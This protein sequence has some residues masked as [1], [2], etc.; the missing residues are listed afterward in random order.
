MLPDPVWGWF[1]DRDDPLAAG[2]VD[3]LQKAGIRAFGPTAKAAEIESS[4]VFSKNLMK[5]YQIP[6]L[7]Y[8]EEKSAVII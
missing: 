5:K 1:A 4:K 8:S 6:T 7:N 3:E 2:M